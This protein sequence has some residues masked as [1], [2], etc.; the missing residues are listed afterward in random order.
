MTKQKLP[1]QPAHIPLL[2]TMVNMT[3]RNSSSQRHLQSFY[4]LS[5]GAFSPPFLGLENT[6]LYFF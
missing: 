5:A 2:C 4:M 3:V 1:R 6:P